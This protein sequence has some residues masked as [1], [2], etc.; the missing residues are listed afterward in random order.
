MNFYD[1]GHADDTA[2][3]KTEKP[4]CLDFKHGASLTNLPTYIRTELCD[5][6]WTATADCY[7]NK[8]TAYPSKYLKYLNR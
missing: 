2:M 1:V 6:A 8:I 3:R 7:E 5:N 4:Q